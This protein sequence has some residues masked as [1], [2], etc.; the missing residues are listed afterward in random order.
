MQMDGRDPTGEKRQVMRTF[1]RMQFVVLGLTSRTSL[2]A[3]SCY[4]VHR[5]G[6]FVARSTG[7]RLIE[8]R[9]K[10]SW[11]KFIDHC[12]IIKLGRE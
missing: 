6:L 4:V 9:E 12:V 11:S 5:C 2:V 7:S 10:R 8:S 3:S 1:G